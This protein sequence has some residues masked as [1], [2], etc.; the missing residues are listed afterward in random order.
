MVERAFFALV[1]ERDFFYSCYQNIG[2]NVPPKERE[3]IK[4]V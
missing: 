3:H 4:N 2:W 1:V